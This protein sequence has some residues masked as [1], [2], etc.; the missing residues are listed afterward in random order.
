MLTKREVETAFREKGYVVSFKT[1]RVNK[2]LCTL[3]IDALDGEAVLHGMAFTAAAIL[4]HREA[5]N[6]FHRFQGQRM[7]NGQK[8]L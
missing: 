1:N 7:R 6:L 3:F 5:F 4:K 8:I 2:K